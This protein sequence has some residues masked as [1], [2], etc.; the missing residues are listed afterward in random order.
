LDEDTLFILT[1]DHGN[2]EDLS[3]RGHTFNPVPLVARGPHAGQILAGSTSLIDVMSRILRV[4][5]PE[6][7]SNR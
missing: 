7:E 4:I 3:T 1:S 6:G 5:C 2:I